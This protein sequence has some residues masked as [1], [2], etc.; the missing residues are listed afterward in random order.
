MLTN[1]FY[2]VIILSLMKQIPHPS[3]PK[4]Y[5][6]KCMSFNNFYWN[7]IDLLTYVTVLSRIPESRQRKKHMM[8]YAVQDKI[9]PLSVSLPMLSV[10]IS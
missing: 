10:C 3:S 6:K 7:Y 2:I 9:K 5:E 1:H 8:V 4:L